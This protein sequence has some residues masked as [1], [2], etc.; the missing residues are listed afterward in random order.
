MGQDAIFRK[1]SLDRLASPEQ[2]DQLMRVTDARGWIALLAIGIVRITATAW[3]VVGSIP[4]NVNGVG[5]LI[6][7]GGVFDVMPLAGGRVLDVAVGVGDL[8]TEGQVVARIE[9]TE[10]RDR[11]QELKA[12]LVNLREQH[13]QTL[14]HGSRDVELQTAYLAK[15]RSALDQAIASSERSVG[16]YAEKIASQEKLVEEGLLTRQTLL[17]SRQQQDAE[18]AKINDAHSQLA[19]IQVKE[20]ELQLKRQEEIVASRT[21]IDDQ[22]RAIAE[23]ERDL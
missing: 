6:K 15:Q 3:G 22:A 9:Q 14:D 4:Q 13:Q 7:S 20:S 11:L 18:R 12:T 8:V 2:L 10:L 21:K 19:Q 23:A 17:T 16:W 1:V 5:I